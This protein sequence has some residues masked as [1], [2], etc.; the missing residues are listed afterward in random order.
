YGTGGSDLGG[1]S[2]PGTLSEELRRN[3]I[4]PAGTP[5]T[6]V[7]PGATQRSAVLEGAVTIVPDLFTN[8]LLIRA[9]EHDA[10]LLRQ[11]V[12]A[13][14]L[15]PLQVVI[16]VVIVEAQRDQQRA[17]GLDLSM[18]PTAVRGGGAGTVQ[19]HQ[20]GGGLGDFVLQ[21]LNLGPN[22]VNAVLQAGESNGTV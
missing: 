13:L 6:N 1:G 18:G 20:T 22:Q 5:Q 10:D 19:A 4:P 21:V 8:S 17:W 2:R 16:E 15:R 14:D 11:A 9:T 12:A 3:L 7:A